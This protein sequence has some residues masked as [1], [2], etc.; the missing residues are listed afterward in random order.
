MRNK[1]ISDKQ[2]DLYFND[3]KPNYTDSI[4]K[5]ISENER[6]D[7]HVSIHFSNYDYNDLIQH[8]A[9]LIMNTNKYETKILIFNDPYGY[10]SIRKEDILGFL[11]NGNVELFQF[12]PIDYI[13]RFSKLAIDDSDGSQAITKFLEDFCPDYQTYLSDANY[14]QIL[15][16]HIKQ[17]LTFNQK[18]LSSSFILDRGLNRYFC[19]FYVTN[20]IRG[21]EV[22]NE[23]KWKLDSTTGQISTRN[24]EQLRLF[25]DHV[26][27][28]YLDKFK[29]DLLGFIRSSLS[30]RTNIDIYEFTVKND[31][32]CRHATLCLDLLR[33]DNL[34]Q[35]EFIGR[36]NA[37]GITYPNYKKG[38]TKIRVRGVNGKN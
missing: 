31:S 27:D 10:K 28:D 2:L 35:V 23:A 14:V 17:A 5:Y 22:M 3:L 26:H 21:L 19:L 33:N 20:H 11:S 15:Q 29:L 9:N 13:K 24:P 1:I 18:F 38:I 34:I 36:N 30:Y 4:R 12:I 16:D 8:I 25:E 6:H 32:V 37:Y 7:D